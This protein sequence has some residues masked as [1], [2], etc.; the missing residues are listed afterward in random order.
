MSCSRVVPLMAALARVVGTSVALSMSAAALSAAAVAAQ[1][2]P[3]VA[4]QDSATDTPT[5]AAEMDRVVA[6]DA[7]L[8]PDGRR[9][10]FRVLES[11]AP[12]LF[13]RDVLDTAAA[14][15]PLTPPDLSVGGY[16][17]TPDSRQI[18][19]S[20]E[21]GRG[22]MV[23]RD[24]DATVDPRAAPPPSRELISDEAGGVRIAGF[25]SD[26]MA[27]LAEIPGSWPDAPDLVRID[28][29]TGDRAVVVRNEGGVRRWLPDDDGLP[30]LAV[31]ED[32]DGGTEVV[33]YREGELLPVYRCA[34]REVCEP[35][36]FHPDGR[37][38][39]RSDRGRGTPALL[40][41]DP[42][43]SEMEVVR[44]DAGSDP[45]SAF[46]EDETFDAATSAVQSAVQASEVSPATAD[47]EV[48]LTFHEPT[49]D[50][51]RWLVTA[52]GAGGAELLL[53][54]RWAGTVTSVLPLAGDRLPSTVTAVP[55]PSTLTPIELGYRTTEEGTDAPPV[56][57]TRRIER[58]T[59]EGADVWR[60]VDR[61]DVPMYTMPDAD[62]DA[63]VAEAEELTGDES[64]AEDPFGD[65]PLFDPFAEPTAPTGTTRATDTTIL[66]A[67][68][69]VP[70]L[71][72]AEGAVDIRL[73]LTDGGVSGVVA[74]QDMETPVEAVVDGAVWFDGAALEILVSALPL[75]ASYRTRVPVFEA[76]MSAVDTVHVTV[77]GA[78]EVTT[79]AGSFDVWRITLSSAASPERVEEWLVRR[80]APH[81]LV[82]AELRLD[83]VVRITELVDAGGLR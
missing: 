75:D 70:L 53:F 77:T 57:M 3:V 25:A 56:E 61:A 73:D 23:V 20:D 59:E 33:R 54:D 13:V 19:F 72:R 63:L 44:E 2:P 83:D 43:T 46:R 34:A 30:R 50:R 26:P 79:P 15:G 5:T 48:R 28:L 69:L 78:D 17:W 38:W 58:D 60:V 68:T 47:G 37:V 12:R 29:E 66:D 45:R 80:S 76:Q 39:M 51:G 18:V 40:L 52:R 55:E 42:L 21:V 81:Y 8:S 14:P 41:L 16:A 35:V 10:A 31:R 6:L 74:T 64:R 1:E 4:A 11:G 7:A 65:E 32:E 36:A 49:A 27:V 71:R 62:L 67:G 22:L 9:L 82:R 24:E